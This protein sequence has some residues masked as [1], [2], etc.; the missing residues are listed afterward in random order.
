MIKSEMGTIEISGK[1]VVILAE[2][3]G[4]LAALKN[5]MHLTDEKIVEILV[6]SDRCKAI[7]CSR[8]ELEATR[9]ENKRL[10]Q[11]LLMDIDKEQ[12]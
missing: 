7:E 11:E 9:E 6:R 8:K 12:S 1:A 10:A 4:L 3:E 2:F 5:T